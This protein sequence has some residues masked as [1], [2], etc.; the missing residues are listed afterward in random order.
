MFLNRVQPLIF[1]ILITFLCGAVLA[2]EDSD[3]SPFA[4]L[5]VDAP[6][7]SQHVWADQG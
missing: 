4:V 2:A 3:Q 1:L 6:R 5:S 7:P